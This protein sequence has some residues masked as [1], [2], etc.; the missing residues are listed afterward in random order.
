M[1][2]T[3]PL[4]ESVD[5]FKPEWGQRECIAELRRIAEAEP[6]RVIT[7]NY[8]RNH[9]VCSESTW[10]RYFGSWN[11][12][13]SQAGVTLSRVAKR[14]EAEIARHASVDRMRQL[15]SERYSYAGAY[16][17]PNRSRFKRTLI[18]TDLHDIWCDP[19]WLR[20]FVDAA[21]RIQPDKIV[22]GGDLFDLP[23]FSKYTVDPRVW[24]PV[25]RIKAAHV[26][27]RS[28]REAAPDAEIDLLEGNH[29][30]RLLRFLAEAT[31]A[32]RTILADLHGFTVARLFGLDEFEVNY[33]A[34]ADLAVFTPRDVN[35]EIKKNHVLCWD[36]LLVHH[37]P[38]GRAMG[39]PGC[40]GHHHAHIVWPHYTKRYG[41]SEWHQLGGGC[42]R[43]A[44]YC[45]GDKWSNGFAVA[46]TDVLAL[47]T[48]F[49][50]VEVRDFA[51]LG[52][53]Y[54]RRKKSEQF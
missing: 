39:V 14:L 12:F 18:G 8:F 35:S 29:E 34:A 1:K 51:V 32:L 13:K 21:R 16:L 38:A 49:E 46:H 47:K 28:L 26:I 37:F 3:V 27:L 4:S 33:H 44:E 31:P 42:V 54:Y 48:T 20:V 6:E 2:T 17:K 45:D 5:K 43:R 52:G 11:E 25:G 50:Y 7:R 9:A 23:E 19:F 22:I 40:H 30:F 53:E 41:A 36:S 15:N 10:T 24:N